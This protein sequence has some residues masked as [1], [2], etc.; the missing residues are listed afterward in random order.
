MTL[1]RDL[2]QKL[3]TDEF[4]SRFDMKNSAQ[5]NSNL[6]FK[7]QLIDVN[8]Q[9]KKKLFRTYSFTSN[10]GQSL[11]NKTNSTN[12]RKFKSDS[13]LMSSLKKSTNLKNQ[14]EQS[15]PPFSKLFQ[16]NN[17]LEQFR[18]L[19]FQHS[20]RRLDPQHNGLNRFDI[21]RSD[22]SLNGKTCKL[23]SKTNRSF[24]NCDSELQYQVPLKVIAHVAKLANSNPDS[25]LMMSVLTYMNMNAL[26][27]FSV[28]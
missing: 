14:D 7:N 17:A 11:T 25:S 15:T 24:L 9:R 13:D 16:H 21:A 6:M 20:D 2:Y 23:E 28:K 22:C 19:N 3:I 1:W 4:E 5:I 18:N 8:N 26:H 12:L 10:L 27:T